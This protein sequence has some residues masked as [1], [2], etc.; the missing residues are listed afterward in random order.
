MLQ[1]E[2]ERWYV[3]AATLKGGLGRSRRARHVAE[4][5]AAAPKVWQHRGCFD[6]V[7]CGQ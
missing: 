1:L 7:S 4:V 6:I 5:G 2:S 3:G